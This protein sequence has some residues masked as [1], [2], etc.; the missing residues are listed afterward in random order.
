MDHKHL[1]LSL[2]PLIEMFA[3]LLGNDTEIALHDLNTH[4]LVYIVNGHVTG[5]SAGYKMSLS[6][7]E[8]ILS[9]MDTSDYLIGYSTHSSLGTSIRASHVLIRDEDGTPAALI[10]VNQDV[11]RFKDLRDYLDSLISL[12]TIQQKKESSPDESEES[13]IQKITQNIILTTIEQSK[14]TQLDKK[15]KKLEILAA[16]EAK[17]VF[18]VKDATPTVCKML[19]ISQATLYN[20]LRE[21]RSQESFKL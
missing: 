5:R 1:I 21:I 13:S 14:P 10:C 3:K 17:G 2:E 19:S 12:T 18:S 15:E 20:Y 6:V 7:Y 11:S 4:Q 8:T 9:L 16:L